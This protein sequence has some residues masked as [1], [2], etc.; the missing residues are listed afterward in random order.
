MNDTTPIIQRRNINIRIKY[1][2]LILC[3]MAILIGISA[4]QKN[5]L[6]TK[7][8]VEKEQQTK[9]KKIN[10]PERNY[11][12][13]AGIT[14]HIVELLKETERETK[15][16]ALKTDIVTD[17]IDTTPE[18]IYKSLTEVQISR[19]MDLTETTGLSREDFCKLLENFKCDY[20]G[21]YKRNA[22]WI[23]DLG[24]EYKVNEIFVC[25][26]FALESFYGS[27]ASHVKAHNYG[28]I[29]TSKVVSVTD[30]N[31][32]EKEITIQELKTYLTDEE[33]IEAN[34]KLFADC[35]LSP[36]GKY[37]KGVTLDSIGDTY[38]PPTNDCPS[39]ADKVYECMQV[40]LE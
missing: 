11:K 27:N 33:G 16:E 13:S 35:Y 12:L 15:V 39:W 8:T 5:Q 20:D 40:F 18:I 22:G 19:G 21:F 36:D 2:I 26:V 6:E 30:E 38:C 4:I 37:Y 7:K 24:Q 1:F 17:A 25:G 23:W 29:M 31:G 28:S 34:F 9:N 10:L 3:S 32:K 14:Q